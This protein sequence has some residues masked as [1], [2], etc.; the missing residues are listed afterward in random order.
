MV[1]QVEGYYR[2]NKRVVKRDSADK[3]RDEL[4]GLYFNLA[5][6]KN[7]GRKVDYRETLLKKHHKCFCKEEEDTDATQYPDFGC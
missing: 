4:E 1:D 3:A 2:V 7:D 5:M 6:R